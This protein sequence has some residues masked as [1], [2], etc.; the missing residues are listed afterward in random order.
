MKYTFEN[1]ISGTSA[2]DVVV[3]Y[4]GRFQPAHKNHAKVYKFLKSYFPYAEVYVATSNKIKPPKS[5]FAFNEKK[6]MLEAAG[7]PADKIIQTVNPY[8]AR[9]ITNKFNLPTTKI[10][11]A[12]GEKDM[13]KNNPR[14]NFLPTK[15]GDAYFKPLPKINKL[16]IT[17]IELLYTA[18]KH[19]YV[20]IAPTYNFTINI[21]GSKIP[22]KGAS[23]IRELY[24]TAS[25][26][27]KQEIINQLYGH[28]DNRIYELFNSKLI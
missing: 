20:A 13:D 26:L 5:P 16:K 17:D 7:I 8:Q 28:F 11:F 1:F 4:P 24:K 22:I 18:D 12:V 3:I 10:I 23:E 14:F 6:I 21:V 19:G 15:K 9:E 25:D 27:G 2:Q